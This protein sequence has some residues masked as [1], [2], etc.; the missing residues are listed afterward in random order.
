MLPFKKILFPVDYSPA[1]LAMAPYVTDMT[2]HFSA[3]LLLIHAYALRPVFVNRDI[4]SVMVYSDLAYTDPKVM[5]EARLIEEQ[6]LR[7]FAAKNFPGLNAETMTE[8]GEAGAA[9]H[10]VLQHQGA[11]LVMMPTRGDGPLRRFLLG[12]VTA[13]V[14]HDVSAAVWTGIGSA[15]EGH[16]PMVP[17]KSIV[18]ALDETQESEVVLRAA[19]ALAKS[20][21]AKLTLMHVFEMPPA[22]PEMDLSP[23]RQD[24]IDAANAHLQGLKS[25]LN[26]DAPHTVIDAGVADGIHQEVARRK[27][28]LVIVGRGHD[29]GIISR[30]WSRLYSIVR[31]S[32]CPVLSI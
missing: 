29:Q 12:S 10:R 2:R 6:R 5:E 16:A 1:C 7:E 24:L 4:E 30:V 14:L 31:D 32:P 21:Q 23:Y 15:I 28:D 27:A 11:D 20:Y 18:C 26:L 17:Y 8:E 3:E 22:T 19:A 9:I 25:R 13:K